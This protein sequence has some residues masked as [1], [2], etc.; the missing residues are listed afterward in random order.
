MFL[1]F[2]AFSFRLF[3]DFSCVSKKYI[4]MSVLF[5][6]H[7]AKH[8]KVKQKRNRIIDTV[9]MVQNSSSNSTVN[10]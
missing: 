2:L 9:S 3:I 7:K 1:N 10:T 8:Y 5:H 4:Q 6:H